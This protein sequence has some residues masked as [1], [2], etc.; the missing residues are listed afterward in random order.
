MF[1][2][3]MKCL[4]VSCLVFNVVT[5]LEHFNRSIHFLEIL[6]YP[7]HNMSVTSVLF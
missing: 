5:N 4:I 3:V 6:T 7:E 2:E 1:P